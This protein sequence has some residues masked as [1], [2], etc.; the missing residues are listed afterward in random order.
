MPPDFHF[1]PLQQ[2]LFHGLS[3]LLV[4]RNASES[5]TSAHLPRSPTHI[6]FLSS[7][8]KGPDHGSSSLN[9]PRL[10]ISPLAQVP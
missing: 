2:W 4:F 7:P 3:H 1:T 6:P 8:L 5:T 9:G 10:V